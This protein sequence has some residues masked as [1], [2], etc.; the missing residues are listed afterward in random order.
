MF[1]VIFRLCAQQYR[2]RMNKRQNG[3]K[4][5]K[6]AIQQER[7]HCIINRSQ[8][9]DNMSESNLHILISLLISSTVVVYAGRSGREVRDHM[10]NYCEADHWVPYRLDGRAD[11]TESFFAC[12]MKVG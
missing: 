12:V 4:N 3:S 10:W 8:K 5:R 7:Q 9:R 6:I 2:Q 11:V 1:S